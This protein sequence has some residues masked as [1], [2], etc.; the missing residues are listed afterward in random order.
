MTPPIT[1]LG[2]RD[3]AHHV[4]SNTDL[5]A[6]ERDGPLLITR[7]EG[8]Y[9]FDEHGRRY[10]EGMSGL[11][12][13]GLGFSEPR[14]VE[15]ASRQ[16]AKLPYYQDFTGR[17]ADCTAELAARLAE[18]SPPGLEHVLFACSGS[19]ANDAAVKL[20]RY[21]NNARGRPEKKII[22]SRTGGYHGVTIMAG[23][24]TGLPGTHGGFDLPGPGVVHLSRPHYPREALPNESE[25]QFTARLASELDET[26]TRLGAHT[27]GALIAEPV[28]GAGGVVP[29]PA[30]YFPGIQAVLRRH[31]VLLIVDE[32]I[33]GFARTG[34]MFASTLY[35][36]EPDLMVVAKQM[37][38]G[39]APMSAVLMTDS[40]Y[41]I[42]ADESARR[43]V[44]GHGFTYAGHPVSAAVAL[45]VL[46]IY[47]ERDVPARVQA[48]AGPF[49]A[50]MRALLGHP[51]VEEVRGVGLLG[52]VQLNAD[53]PKTAARVAAEALARNVIVR[54]LPNESIGLC[55]P[56]ITAPDE[57]DALFEGLTAALNAA[58]TT[59]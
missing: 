48:A 50:R 51:L 2:R 15:A 41:Q 22:L 39:Y 12:C 17:G 6:L 46:D 43:G 26:I 20:V 35:G 24:L 32:V 55:P 16:L 44:F 25:A 47:A 34:P 23:S 13:C 28:L 53:R 1:A 57:L 59:A 7:G 36:I 42:I 38:S 40:I 8:V 58:A 33:C 21:F 52:G 27:V 5:R 19:E 14:L 18:V 31:D 9:V 3:L 4:H 56:L 10:L 37:T 54:V 49:Q 45:E 30:G 11:W 29:P